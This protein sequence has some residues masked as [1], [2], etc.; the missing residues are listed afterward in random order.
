MAKIRT[1]DLPVDETL[2]EGQ[3]RQIQGGADDKKEFLSD[4]KGL[5]AM[6]EELSGYLGQVSSIT[7]SGKP[8]H[9]PAGWKPAP[10]D[11]PEDVK[12]IQ[13]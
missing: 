9:K 1:D 13:L 8:S 11:P 2:S 10:A 6:G 12:K 3:M 5:N 7:G 4:L